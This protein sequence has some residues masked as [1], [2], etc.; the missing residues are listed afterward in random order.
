[1]RSALEAARVS[2]ASLPVIDISDLSSGSLADRQAVGAALRAAC[3]DKGFFYIKNHGVS[4][5]LVDDVFSEAA[6]FFALPAAQKAEVGKTKSKANRGYEPLQGQTLEA[7]APP[8]L[9]EGYYVGP[10]HSADDP[11]VVAGM[12]NHGANQWPAQR[13]NFR[14]VM[15]AYLQV[16]L[17]LSARMMRGIALSLDLPED[18]FAHYCSDVMATVR[19]LHYPPQT[20]HAL[21]GQKGAGAHTDFGGLTLLRQDNVGGLQVWDQA[22]DGWIHAD[23]VPATFIVNLGDMISR[24]TNDR[25]RS[26]VHRVVNASG[27]ERYSA[28]FFYTGNYAHRVEC[29]PTCVAPGEVPKYPPTTVEAHMRDMYRRTYKS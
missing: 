20:A 23:P 29:I 18:Y 2:A 22:S 28:P 4:E 21:P 6:G 17:D 8:D 25:Y 12:F 19:L 1:M 27:R 7:G 14:P 15:L 5:S 16:M 26:T 9:K 24:W 11:R 3:L 13:P 10:E